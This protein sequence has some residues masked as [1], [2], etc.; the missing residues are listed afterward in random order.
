MPYYLDSNLT[1]FAQEGAFVYDVLNSFLRSS[2]FA[3]C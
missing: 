1:I 3:P 2:A